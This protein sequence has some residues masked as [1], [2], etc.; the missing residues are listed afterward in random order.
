[1]DTLSRRRHG[2]AR[3]ADASH[4][5]GE[6][7][8]AMDDVHQKRNAL[9]AVVGQENGFD[10]GKGTI[11]DDHAFADLEIRHAGLI[12]RQSFSD[13]FNGSIID[14]QQTLVAM[15]EL[16]N[17]S[18]GADAVPGVIHLIELNEYIAREHR[19]P[20]RNPAALTDLLHS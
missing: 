19:L 20:H 4:R 17:S 8:L 9:F 13:A 1:M 2:I 11:G 7:L 18:R 5:E 14:R 12:N 3:F 10:I 16:R 6:R 15:N